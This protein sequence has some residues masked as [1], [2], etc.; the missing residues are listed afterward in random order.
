[1]GAQPA[2]LTAP[3]PHEGERLAG[4][5][6]RL[7]RYHF[8]SRRRERM[9]IA[10]IGFL[11]TV[12][13]VRAITHLI[14]ADIGPFHNVTTGGLH[15]HHLVWGILLLLVVGYVWLAEVGVAWTWTAVLTAF[16]FGIGAALTLDEFALWLN[17]RD[18]YWETQGRESVDAILL[19]ASVLSI[20]AWG[21]PFLAALGRHMWH[22]ARHLTVR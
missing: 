13:I 12:G 14:R 22:R 5:V 20:G 16:V 10:S 2:Q 7:Y 15:I 6:R 8:A 18:V 21:G 9:F 17:L 11:A 3:A 19:F 4:F 1:M